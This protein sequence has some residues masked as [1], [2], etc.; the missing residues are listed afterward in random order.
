MS[1]EILKH[2][3]DLRMKVAGKTLPDLFSEALRGM[4]SVL[5]SDAEKGAAA[6]KRQVVMEAGDTTALLVDFL[7]EALSLAQTRKEIYTG[8]SFRMFTETSLEAELIGLAV[9]EFDEDIKA[10]TY[11]EAD[12]KRNEMGEWETMLVFDI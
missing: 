1:Y 11:H 10:V 12:V 8:A 3:A 5:K 2:T 7:S 4:M 6:V 9:E